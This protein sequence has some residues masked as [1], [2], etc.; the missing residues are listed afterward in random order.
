M[1]LHDVCNGGSVLSSIPSSRN[2]IFQHRDSKPFT[3]T[4]SLD[5]ITSTTDTISSVLPPSNS[6]MSP[7]PSPTAKSGKN[8]S[9]SLWKAMK[10]F[11]T[12]YVPE[13]FNLK[14]KQNS[15]K[16]NS[17]AASKASS[18]HSVRASPSP[19]HGYSAMNAEERDEN[20]KAVITYCN[21]SM[22][23]GRRKD[24]MVKDCT[25]NG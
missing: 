21:K 16:E 2:K 19:D 3:R 14:S 4:L 18:V 22:K 9:R 1:E 13:R 8:H 10:Q 12:C 6:M 15:S 5:S 17:V 7:K 25:G 23:S 20:I 24:I 11:F